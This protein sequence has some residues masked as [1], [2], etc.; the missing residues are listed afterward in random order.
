MV[1]VV[2]VTKTD[3]FDVYIGRKYNRGKYD[4]KESIFN[5]PFKLKDFNND[6][7]KC[8]D[9]Y[10]FYLYGKFKLDEFFAKELLE[11]KDKTLGCWCKPQS[12][13]GDVIK[14]LIEKHYANQLI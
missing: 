11:I 4:F 8:L 10:S 7:D 6:R 5:N 3:K 9:A 12:C 1:E 2:N 14:N 13:H